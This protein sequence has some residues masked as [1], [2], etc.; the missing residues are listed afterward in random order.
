MVNHY[1]DWL[2]DWHWSI[3]F[4]FRMVN[5]LI[6]WL[7]DRFGFRKTEKKFFKKN[8]C[9]RRLTQQQQQNILDV[10]GQGKMCNEFLVDVEIMMLIEKIFV[11]I[12]CINQST[13]YN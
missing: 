2:I 11:Q 9:F 6:D 13:E 8:A 10:F 5:W 7:D 4:L 3:W 1:H 12:F